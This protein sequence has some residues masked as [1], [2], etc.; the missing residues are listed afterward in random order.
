MGQSKQFI[1][2]LG[3]LEQLPDLLQRLD[4]AL[5]VLESPDVILNT[6]GAA[7]LLNVSEG[8]IRSLVATRD[9]P[10]CAIGNGWRFSRR[11]LLAWFNRRAHENLSQDV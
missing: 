4:Q 5:S 9:L 1:L 6:A 10:A 11:E 3:T 8:E 7:A 2:D